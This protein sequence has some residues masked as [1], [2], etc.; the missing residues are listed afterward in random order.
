MAAIAVAVLTTALALPIEVAAIA[1]GWRDAL[2]PATVRAVLVE[3]SAGTAWQAQAVAALLL[4]ATLLAPAP[5]R[6]GATAAASG[7]LLATLAL[8]G[9]AAMQGGWPG[10]AHRLNDAV[11][12]LAGGAWF[13]ALVPLLPL[14]GALGDPATTATPGS[15]CGASR[16]RAT[17]PS[18]WSSRPGP[19]T[20][21]WSSAIG[22]STGLCPIRLCWLRRS[23]WS[24]S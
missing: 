24:P 11:H 15:P 20:P 17:G 10:V 19:S 4:A 12:V 16:P 6:I 8:T 5:S 7:L 1:S 21:R 13:G 23:H 2:D 22:R 18:P 9:H 3:T 14:L